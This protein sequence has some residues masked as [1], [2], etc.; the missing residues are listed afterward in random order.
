ME[1]NQVGVLTREVS[2]T[3]KTLA[4]LASEYG[5]RIKDVNTVRT[6]LKDTIYVELS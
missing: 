3:M 1:G 4:S 2:E 5:L 6:S